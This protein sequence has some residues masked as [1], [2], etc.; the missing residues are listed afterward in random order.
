ML[1]IL[2]VLGLVAPGAPHHIPIIT[3]YVASVGPPLLQALG[4]DPLM[5]TEITTKHDA[6]Y[7]LCY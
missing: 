5:T 7:H 2:V 1:R 6:R 4:F 3:G